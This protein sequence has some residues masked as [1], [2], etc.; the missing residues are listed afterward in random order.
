MFDLITGQSPRDNSQPK[1]L[2]F[3]NLRLKKIDKISQQLSTSPLSKQ[4]AAM[5]VTSEHLLWCLNFEILF[6]LLLSGSGSLASLITGLMV[7]KKARTVL[8]LSI[9]LS[10]MI[11]TARTALVSSVNVP[12]IVSNF[13]ISDC[14]IFSFIV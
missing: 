6:V 13:Y 9:T 3:D 4:Q 14:S 1:L 12:L 7:T 10:G 11:S 8:A 5:K 2:V